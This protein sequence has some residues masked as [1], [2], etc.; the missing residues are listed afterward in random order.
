M[1][2]IAIDRNY[3]S[4]PAMDKDS[5]FNGLRANSQFQKLRLAGMACHNDF[6]NNHDG[7]QFNRAQIAAAR[8][9]ADLSFPGSLS[10]GNVQTKS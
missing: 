8:I 6:T 5:F 1:L 7:R 3:C 4:Y 9:P 2:K 10:C